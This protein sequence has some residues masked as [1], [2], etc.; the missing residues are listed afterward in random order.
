MGCAGKDAPGVA[1]V[2]QVLEDAQT[3]DVSATQAPPTDYGGN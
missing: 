1:D 2:K 3:P